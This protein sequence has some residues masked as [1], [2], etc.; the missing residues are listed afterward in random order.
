[1]K[2]DE[3]F[4][5]LESFSPFLRWNYMIVQVENYILSQ[6]NNIIYLENYK[7]LFDKKS[8]NGRF[9]IHT[10]LLRL[11]ELLPDEKQEDFGAIL[12]FI[13]ERDEKIKQLLSSN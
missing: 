5:K 6:E 8:W 1:M 11:G 7:N 4:K 2:T 13:G 9:I 3:I 10:I 12:K